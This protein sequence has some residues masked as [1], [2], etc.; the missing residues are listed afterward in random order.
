MQAHRAE[1]NNR[2]IV[3]F[4]NLEALSQA[5]AV[6]FV[7]VANSSI[8]KNGRFSVAL[9]GGSTPKVLYGL[10]ANPPYYSQVDWSKVFFFFG[11]ER[12]VAPDHP[13]S[14]YRMASEAL[15]AK[16][17][18]PANQ[19]F[20]MQGEN[21]DYEAAANTYAQELQK[22][23]G[24]EAGHGPSPENFPRLDLVL[25]GMGPDGHTASLF[26]GTKALQERGRP[27]APNYVEKLNA[28]RLTLTA[29]TINRA[30]QV[31]FLIGGSD[32]AA[33]LHQVLEGEYQPEVY[34][35]QLI[36]APNGKLVFFVD[37]T[38]AAQLTKTN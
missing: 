30:A 29:P 25:L 1:P 18:L 26:P 13:D 14:N 31:L 17:N 8:A 6:R 9:S 11:D 5:A 28:H 7:E 37:Q 12:C 16:L 22:F 3:I 27:V 10:L 32:K 36:Q 4:D 2:E 33:P 15:L 34:P 20:R 19:V 38:A 24:L 35:S 21:P 23:F